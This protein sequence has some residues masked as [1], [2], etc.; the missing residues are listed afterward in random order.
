MKTTHNPCHHHLVERVPSSAVACRLSMQLAV[1]VGAIGT[2]LESCWRELLEFEDLVLQVGGNLEMRTA[3]TRMGGDVTIETQKI[4]VVVG[5]EH[6]AT[7]IEFVA[8][9]VVVGKMKAAD[10][11]PW[12]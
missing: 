6:A 8:M 2:S 1:G 11:D 3:V 7:G 12:F 5:I 10:V 4:V 9:A